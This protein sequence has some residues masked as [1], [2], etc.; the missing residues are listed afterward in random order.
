MGIF[1]DDG[2]PK[3]FCA[4]LVDI[5]YVT[6]YSLLVGS[7]LWTCAKVGHDGHAICA[8]LLITSGYLTLDM[9]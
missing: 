7:Q 3:P 8:S 4:L 2:H 9:C 5:Q 6:F 1:V